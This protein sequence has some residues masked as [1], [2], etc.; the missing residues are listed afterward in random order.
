MA[1][2]TNQRT[3]ISVLTASEWNHLDDTTVYI[4]ASSLECFKTRHSQAVAVS[5]APPPPQNKKKFDEE[6]LNGVS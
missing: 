4:Y 3:H 5:T 1:L 2:L 6:C